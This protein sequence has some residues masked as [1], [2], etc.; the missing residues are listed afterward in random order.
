MQ[1]TDAG[2]MAASQNP[3]E[4]KPTSAINRLLLAAPYG[5][6]MTSDWLTEQGITPQMLWGYKKSGWLVP[7]GR[8]AWIRAG[9]PVDWKAAVYALQRQS[10][11]SVWPAGQTA[12]A[13]LGQAHYIPQGN[14]P[15][16]QLS[17]V[18][19]YRL[20]TWFERLPF[21]SNIVKCNATS[22]FD[23]V[24]I[25]LGCWRGSAFD[26]DISSPERAAIELCDMTPANA[27]P[28]EVMELV[29]GLP[30]LRPALLQKLL[31]ACRSIKAKRLLLVLA[32]ILE[33]SWLNQL[34]ITQL[35][36]GSGKRSLKVPGRF[37]PRYKIT[38]PAAWEEH[39]GHARF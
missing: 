8:G 9:Q 23:V 24:D 2:L 18:R 27:D 10:P 25:G 32:E 37:H 16:I 12:L 1:K 22:L 13:L 33:H 26:L 6:P 35:D 31:T 5:V 28:E 30:A 36:L 29:Q 21:G 34:D 19:G 39:E 15:V 4:M 17:T 38:V 14:D 3:P 7:L 20:P 11:N